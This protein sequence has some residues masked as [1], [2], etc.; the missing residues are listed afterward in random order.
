M[1]IDLIDT[2]MHIEGQREGGGSRVLAAIYVAA[3]LAACRRQDRGNAQTPTR[4][5][6]EL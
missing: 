6:V 5:A 4:R 1:W 2:M 3:V